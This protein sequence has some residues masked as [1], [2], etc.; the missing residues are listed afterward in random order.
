MAYIYQV[1]Q[2]RSTSLKALHGRQPTWEEESRPAEGERGRVSRGSE[3]GKHA[4]G[5]VVPGASDP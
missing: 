4:H 1:L 3:E 2:A 5:G